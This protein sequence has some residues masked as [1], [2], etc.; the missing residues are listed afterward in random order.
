MTENELVNIV[1]N[2]FSEF[3][4]NGK[5]LACI[6]AMSKDFD[7]TFFSDRDR[8]RFAEYMLT[9]N[10]ED[11]M[12]LDRESLRI[13]KYAKSLKSEIENK[14]QLKTRFESIQNSENVLSSDVASILFDDPE[15]MIKNMVLGY[16]PEK[17]IS[18]TNI[19][20]FLADVF[21]VQRHSLVSTLDPYQVLSKLNL[22]S[23]IQASSEYCKILCKQKLVKFFHVIQNVIRKN[24]DL[25]KENIKASRLLN[26]IDFLQ[27]MI[28]YIGS[29]GYSDIKKMEG[30]SWPNF[31]KRLWHSFA[32]SLIDDKFVPDILS[33]VKD[34]GSSELLSASHHRNVF[35]M[36][37]YTKE[38]C[39]II[40]NIDFC[41]HKE[42][43][44]YLKF[45]IDVSLDDKE[46]FD[47]FTVVM[48]QHK[49]SK[50]S[51]LINHVIENNFVNYSVN[52]GC[53]YNIFPILMNARPRRLS[54]QMVTKLESLKSLLEI[55]MG[56]IVGSSQD[57]IDSCQKYIADIT[58]FLEYDKSK[59]I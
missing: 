5:T 29:D 53:Y 34:Y 3:A 17:M 13:V 40:K 24:I 50:I 35:L 21:Q 43:T 44:N 2:K 32:P 47:I 31:E 14:V 42:S 20:K 19:N 51:P 26:L 10:S 30:E 12:E 18:S 1:R 11:G 6:D 49:I 46:I 52:N 7:N 4:S 16:Y 8:I 33:I 36:K 58:A 45:L 15:E 57:K 23:V 28:R 41:E 37:T 39:D 22:D 59:K 54:P 9:Q 55:R 48:D 56:T 25:I 27:S 38:Y